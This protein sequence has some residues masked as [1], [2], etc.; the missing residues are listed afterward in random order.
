MQRSPLQSI[1]YATATSYP[2]LHFVDTLTGQVELPENMRRLSVSILLLLTSPEFALANY[3]HGSSGAT[4]LTVPRL[5]EAPVIDGALDDEVWQRAAVLDS[6]THNRPLEGVLD[7]LGTHCLVYYDEQYLYVGFR[8]IDD[9]TQVQAPIVPRDQIWQ[10]DWVGVSI[11]T[12]HDRQRSFFFGAN[13]N[14][15][16]MDGV[17]QEGSDTDLS[18]DFLYTSKGRI[19]DYGYEVEMAIPFKSLRFPDQATLTFGFNAIR[20]VRRD[21]THMYWAPISRD[22]NSYH[23]Q[24]G[25]LQ[26]IEGVQP[27]KDLRLIPTA[28]ASRLGLRGEDDVFTTYDVDNRIGFDVQYGVTNSLT[29]NGTV[30]PDFS[31]VESDASVVDIN[32]RFA[33]FFPERRPFFL[34]GADIFNSPFQLVYTRRIVDPRGGLKLTGKQGGL[35]MGVLSALDQSAGQ[36]VATLPNSANPY[37]DHDAL[38]NVARFKQDMFSNSFVGVTLADKEHR[39][40]YNRVAGVDGR[41]NWANIYNFTFQSAGSWTKQADLR[42]AIGG[43]PPDVDAGLD[44]DLRTLT[45]KESNGGAWYA[46]LR[47]NTRKLGLSAYALGVS[48]DFR[49]DMGFITRTNY[50]EYG[51]WFEPSFWAG[52]N[53]WYQVLNTWTGYERT[54]D[55]GSGGRRV[56]DIFVQGGELRLPRNTWVGSGYNNVFTLYEGVEFPNQHRLNFWAGTERWQFWR[57]GGSGSIGEEVIFSEVARGKRW[58]WD[59]WSDFRFTRQ[60]DAGVT[61]SGATIRRAANDSKFRDAIIPRVRVSYQFNKELSFRVIGETRRLREYDT[62]SAVVERTETLTL[63]L[64]ATYLVRPGTVVYVGYGSLDEGDY[65]DEAVPQVRSYFA[66]IS[67]LWQR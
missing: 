44:D 56:D 29:L 37:L 16:Q 2:T 55:Y 67:Y 47:R 17:D 7:T 6:F 57:G 8:A 38:F 20:D 24:L 35:S 28:T 60:L 51:A 4:Q 46:S 1:V 65:M 19:T 41:V 39:D 27:G 58:R 26:S 23:S 52:Q 11:D 31:Q 62:S 22:I 64:L 59:L 48:P 13:P 49:A 15:I 32:E 9:P 33:I 12:Y 43:L 50:Q 63:D 66:K 61:V 21:G 54:H 40:A 14:G 53:Q 36:P 18:R 3:H 30:T 45:G 10:G 25:T 5:L 42:D 34:E